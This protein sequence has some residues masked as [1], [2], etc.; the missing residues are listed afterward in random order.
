MNPQQ[1][2]IYQARG[3]AKEEDEAWK[4]EIIKVKMMNELLKNNLLEVNRDMNI[5]F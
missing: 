4:Q 3:N 1:Y 2:A 5:V